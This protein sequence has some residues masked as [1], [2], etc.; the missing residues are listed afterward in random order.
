MGGGAP[1][2]S[3]GGAPWGRGGR[4]AA[5]PEGIPS[6]S[7]LARLSG[8]SGAAPDSPSVAALRFP[9][10]L[11]SSDMVLAGRYVHA[12]QGGGG[13]G[14]GWCTTRL[15]C[16]ALRCGALRAYRR[17]THTIRRGTYLK[18]D[19][20]V[21]YL[22]QQRKTGATSRTGSSSS[23]GRSRR[24]RSAVTLCSSLRCRRRWRLKGCESSKHPCPDPHCTIMCTTATA[25]PPHT[26]TR[27][28]ARAHTQAHTSTHARAHTRRADGES[29]L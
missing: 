12:V 11:L 9:R 5:G 27:T 25:P 10:L 8:S 2:G 18:R 17:R 20:V 28:H 4:G 15:R 14:G 19:L 7:P 24:N 29:A 23:L 13:G 3:G 6:S 22:R 26:H 16:V 1:G 21:F